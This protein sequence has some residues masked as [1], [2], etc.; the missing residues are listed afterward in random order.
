[1]ANGELKTPSYKVQEGDVISVRLFPRASAG[2][3]WAGIQ[4]VSTI[5][6]AV[7]VIGAV[8][9]V[10]LYNICPAFKEWVLGLFSNDADVDTDKLKENPIISGNANSSAKDKPVPVVLGKHLFTPYLLGV[11]ENNKG[12]T[13]PYGTYGEN[14]NF[15][16]LYMVG[17]KPLKVRDIRLKYA[18]LASNPEGIT[19]GEIEVDGTSFS[20]IKDTIKLEIQDER[21]VSIYPQKVVQEN[22]NSQLVH[23]SGYAPVE[24][25]RFS[26]QNPQK[27]QLEVAFQGLYRMDSDGDKQRTSVTVHAEYSF[28]EKNWIPFGFTGGSSYTERYEAKVEHTDKY[29][30]PYITWETRER[31]V[32]EVSFDGTNTTFN[33]CQNQTMYFVAEKEF[34]FAEI[35]SMLPV[36]SAQE[37]YVYMRIWR[38][39]NDSTDSKYC[40]K[41]FL[42]ATRTWCFDKK[43]TREQGVIVPQVPVIEELRKQTVRIGMKIKATEALKGNMDAMNCVVSS[44]APVWD[45]EQWG[46]LEETSNPAS[47]TKMLFSH[48]SLKDYKYPADSIN[49]DKLVEL[50]DYCEDCGFECNTVLVQQQK[51]GDII[52]NVLATGH[53]FPVLDNNQYSFIIDKPQAYPV[54]ILNNQNILSEGLQNTKNFDELPDGLE[55]S[56]INKGVDYKQDRIECY[57]DDSIA[58]DP[59]RRA[60]AKLEKVEYKFVTDRV[61]AWR[62]GKYNLA[63]RKLRPETWVRRVSVDGQM[64]GVGDMVELQDDTI[65]VGIGDGAVVKS[66]ATKNGKVVGILTYSDIPITDIEKDYGVKIIHADGI[67]EPVIKTYRVKPFESEGMYASFEFDTPVNLDE[68]SA[69]D[70]CSFGE[71]GKITTRAICLGKKQDQ[72]NTFELTLVPYSD[73]IFNFDKKPTDPTKKYEIPE[74]ESNVT[75][76]KGITGGNEELPE[77]FLTHEDSINIIQNITQAGSEAIEPPIPPVLKWVHATRDYIRVEWTFD[78]KGISNTIKNFVVM[79]SKDGAYT[80]EDKGQLLRL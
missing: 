40:D 16:G 36:D 24:N 60:Q 47:L 67:N 31:S 64:I 18:E 54:H 62:L 19:S 71:Y 58:D 46:G 51:F 49:N 11:S 25:I 27:I 15:Y 50:Y 59:T 14:R 8:G 13:L 70:L 80:W 65:L 20:S 75:V 17:Y 23:V 39:S 32:K 45:G 9:A 43:K 41:V 2:A 35:A 42:S 76:Q 61:Q 3:I 37:N 68:V 66:V 4:T 48:P 57:Y 21:E 38:V 72:N 79:V 77:D 6:T 63:K 33:M 74:F 73:D 28:D 1:M 7:T 5:L 29:G 10:I 53:A 69:E 22:I 78:G 56:F 52:R 55:I 44:L 30:N 12:Y 34:N 26:A